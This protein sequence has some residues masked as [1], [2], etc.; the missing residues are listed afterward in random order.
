[1]GSLSLYAAIYMWHENCKKIINI[2]EIKFE[3]VVY[4]MAVIFLWLNA[5]IVSGEVGDNYM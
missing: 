3:N 5:L 2:N 1:M 4:E